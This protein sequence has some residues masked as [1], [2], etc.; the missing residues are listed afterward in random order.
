MLVMHLE[1]VTERK[2]E[3]GFYFFL[4]CC[5]VLF[6]EV[7]SEKGSFLVCL[8]MLWECSTVI[9]KWRYLYMLRLET[10][11][12]FEWAVFMCMGFGNLDWDG[13]MGGWVDRASRPTIEYFIYPG[14]SHGCRY[15][16]L[17]I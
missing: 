13:W 8:R 12:A 16:N 17:G 1:K 7:G 5:I 15:N 14:Y 3:R 9:W 6:F 2:K 11:I 4:E 10:W